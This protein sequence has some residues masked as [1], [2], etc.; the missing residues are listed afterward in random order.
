MTAELSPLEQI[1]IN[2]NLSALSVEQR[3]SYVKQLCE[4]LSLNILLRPFD[5]LI[6]REKG[7]EKVAL[8]ANK[9]CSE[10]LARLHGIS[11][12]IL[13]QRIDN[14]LCITTIKGIDKTGRIN[15]DIGVVP[16]S[17][18]DGT[19]RS[20]PDGRKKFIPNGKF[21][22]LSPDEMANARMKSVTKGKRRV[23]LSLGGLGM[24]DESEI[25]TMRDV[26]HLS[27]IPVETI[28]PALT[29]DEN[30]L[31]K[32]Q[33]HLL[34]VEEASKINLKDVY[35]EARLFVG[36]DNAHD[37]ALLKVAKDA[38]VKEL[39][40]SEEVNKNETSNPGYSSPDEF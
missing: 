17:K 7:V 4:A 19:W 32:L 6:T 30:Y 39:L 8:Y 20:E 22:P 1:L 27:E 38:K 36:E 13:D 37:L 9:S 25:E 11:L 12:E 15:T 34:A 14:H 29:R 5:Y 16:V 18:A 28:R 21:I 10:Q 24:L 23:V 35:R 40:A 31:N 33:D 2:G 3:E 26:T